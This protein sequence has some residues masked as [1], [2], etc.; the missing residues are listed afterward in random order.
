M[1]Y[2]VR[3]K[4]RAHKEGFNYAIVDRRPLKRR[5]TLDYDVKVFELPVDDLS[6]CS[7][8]VLCE[9]ACLREA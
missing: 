1:M 3:A 2:L 4:H 5:E 8:I 9:E 7:A 6:L